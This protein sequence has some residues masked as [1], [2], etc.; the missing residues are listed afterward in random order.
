MKI[1]PKL[2][3]KFDIKN[4]YKLMPN[5]IDKMMLKND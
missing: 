4:G 2:T 3:L 5:L 1:D